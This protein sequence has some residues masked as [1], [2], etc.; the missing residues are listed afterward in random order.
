MIQTIEFRLGYLVHF[1][2]AAQVHDGY[3][4]YHFTSQDDALSNLFDK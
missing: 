3:Q 4:R 2:Y 1:L